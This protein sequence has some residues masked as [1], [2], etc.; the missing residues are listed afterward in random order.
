M[1]GVSTLVGIW[2]VEKVEE[3]DLTRCKAPLLFTEIKKGIDRDEWVLN[4]K[5]SLDICIISFLNIIGFY[6]LFIFLI[7]ER[8]WREMERDKFH[9]RYNASK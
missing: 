8:G 1:F 3:Y 4:N 2:N 9:L 5:K 7:I 6:C